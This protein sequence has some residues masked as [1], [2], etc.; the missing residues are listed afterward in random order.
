MYDTGRPLNANA[1]NVIEKSSPTKRA[2]TVICFTMV[3]SPTKSPAFYRVGWGAQLGS[4]KNARQTN[5]Q[6]C[7]RIMQT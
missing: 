6:H 1:P 4:K 3:S 7:D 2:A 5:V